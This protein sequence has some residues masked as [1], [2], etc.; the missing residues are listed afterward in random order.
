VSGR[1]LTTREL[2]RALLARQFLLAREPVAA[3]H[4]IEHLAGMQAQVPRDPY[5]ALWTRI[6]GFDPCELE[7]LIAGR[8]AVRI[9]VMRGT[10]HLLTAR[11]C[12]EF[13]PLM[14]PML[15]KHAEKMFETVDGVARE[16]L[17][18]AVRDIVDARPM[19]Y[20][21]LSREL[22]GRWPGVDGRVLALC[23]RGL[24][25]LVQVTPRGLWTSS[26]PSAHT[27]A[28]AWIGKPLRAKPDPVRFVERYL[29]AFGPAA[30][31]DVTAWSR[32]PGLR[33]ALEELRPKLRTFRDENGRKLFD[34]ADGP[35]PDPDTPAP[36]RFFPEYDNVFLG[37]R[38]RSRVNVRNYFD[39]DFPKGGSFKGSF[40]VDGFLAGFWRIVTSKGAS[41]LELFPT[42]R[43]TKAARDE[44]GDEGAGLLRFCVPDTTHDIRFLS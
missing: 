17:I 7:R 3:K 8:K 2:N 16:E 31:E 37:H 28:E 12:L 11:D 10:I 24:L 34:V 14:R 29:R 30:F 43:L 32:L 4:V 39:M 40:T 13:R 15:A 23:A 6:D 9:V 25:P 41:S 22:E 36:V 42:G 33:P 27:T 21:E 1:V 5:I 18:A 26:G 44:L 19:T 35:L 20:V 38:D